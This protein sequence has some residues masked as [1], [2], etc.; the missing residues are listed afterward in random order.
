M[1]AGPAIEVVAGLRYDSIWF[2][3]HLCQQ[4]LMEPQRLFFFAGES[5]A[6]KA[7]DFAT[8]DTS[9]STY[10]NVLDLATVAQVSDMLA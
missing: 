6:Q 10:A 4:R 3:E 9:M 1:H 2:S 8:R 7:V 5:V